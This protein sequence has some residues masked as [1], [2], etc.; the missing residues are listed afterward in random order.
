MEIVIA[1]SALAVGLLIAEVLLPTGGVLAFIG[2]AGFV[3]AGIVALGEDSDTADYLGPGLIT[4]GVL[5]IATTAIVGRKV[6]R[7][8]TET[9]V[10][11]GK[12][13]MIG[14]EGEV[15]SSLAPIGHIWAD[16][17]LWR[18]KPADEGSPIP[19]GNRVRVESVDGLTLVVRPLDKTTTG[20]E[21]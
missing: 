5:S 16:G 3:A 12:E 9:P 15:R 11:S 14:R 1:L 20:V 13:E 6:Y 18:A 21:D 8:Q 2:A 4:L 19:P 10:R 7:S 17:A